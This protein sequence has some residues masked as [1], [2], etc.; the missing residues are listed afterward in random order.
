MHFRRIALRP[1]H[2]ILDPQLGL[3]IDVHP[4]ETPGLQLRQQRL[5][6]VAGRITVN[7]DPDRVHPV[8][9][10]FRD[11]KF[12]RRTAIVAV[13][14]APV[15]DIHRIGSADPF[16][17][18]EHI[19]VEPQVRHVD[20]RPVLHQRNLGRQLR[21]RQRL[22]RGKPLHDRRVGYVDLPP[23]RRCKGGFVE[24]GL[25]ALPRSRNNRP[26]LAGERHVVR[27]I[28]RIAGL[29]RF[30]GR[31]TD[32]LGARIGFAFAADRRIVPYRHLGGQRTGRAANCQQAN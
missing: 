10:G 29:A 4:A 24:T 18:D 21:R 14:D 20:Y 22:Q 1:D 5:H 19:P 6:P 25:A 27:R 16:H 17:M 12:G 3:R 15:V 23:G 32:K 26:P 13:S 7:L 8:G 2:E 28:G 11:R 9:N 30:T 31:I